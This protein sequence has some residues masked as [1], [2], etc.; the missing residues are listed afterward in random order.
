M[1]R[2]MYTV[3]NVVVLFKLFFQRKKISALIEEIGKVCSVPVTSQK[4]SS[5]LR[6][7][8]NILAVFLWIAGVSSLGIL[9]ISCYYCFSL[10]S[11]KKWA[12]LDKHCGWTCSSH[13]PFIGDIPLWAAFILYCLGFIIEVGVDIF[14]QLFIMLLSYPVG[15][16]FDRFNKSIQ[17]AI[18]SD[19]TA[20]PSALTTISSCEPE[21]HQI[22]DKDFLRIQACFHLELSKLVLF[23]DEAFSSILL[24]MYTVD[25]MGF[26]ATSSLVLTQELGDPASTID[27]EV[28]PVFLA[29][30]GVSTFHGILRTGFGVWLTE[31]AHAV[32][33][34]LYELDLRVTTDEDKFLCSSFVARLQGSRVA[35]TAGGFFYIT[36]EF[37][38][39]ITGVLLTYVLFIY[40]IQ[41]Q[42]QDMAMWSRME[43]SRISVALTDATTQKISTGCLEFLNCT[44]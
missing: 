29:L 2:M 11:E 36:R 16:R 26:I 30:V 23:A 32:L 17:K 24:L 5:D 28:L 19:V 40:Q 7:K 31:K 13:F 27:K 4:F 21:A 33:P 18:S 43:N 25:F 20:P 41:D 9:L 39:S 34:H 22:T 37:V 42:K 10:I 1:Y 8:V 38:I 12:G 14:P 44:Y 3:K 35:L 15:A 6:R